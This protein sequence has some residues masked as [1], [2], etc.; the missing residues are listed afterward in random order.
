MEIVSVAGRNQ[1]K[2]LN[3]YELVYEYLL[4]NKNIAFF[5]EDTKENIKQNFKRFIN[6]NITIKKESQDIFV[7]SLNRSY[8]VNE[9]VTTIEQLVELANEYKAV[10]VTHWKRTSPVAFLVS[11]QARLL[12]RWIKNGIIYTI[13]KKENNEKQK[14]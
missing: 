8:F 12:H 14:G 9:Q 3:T 4:R 1:G 2:S 7:L 13:T 6:V 5:S 11:W 10:Y